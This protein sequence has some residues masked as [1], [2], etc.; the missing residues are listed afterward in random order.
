SS[1]C[2]RQ[3][4]TSVIS[5]AVPSRARIIMNRHECVLRPRIIP[6]LILATVVVA[7]LPPVAGAQIY[8]Y[9]RAD[10]PAT[11]SNPGNVIVADFNGD[12][13]PDLAVSDSRNN[14]VSILLGSPSGGFVAN[15][16][17]ATG[18]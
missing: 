12:G 2:M 11:T 8:L 3:N 4:L 7:F 13:R 16:T 14:W 15:G 17:Y 10:F 9:G 6:T 18:S 1:S 5:S